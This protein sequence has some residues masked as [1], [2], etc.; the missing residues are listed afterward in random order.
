VRSHETRAARHQYPISHGPILPLGGRT[1]DRAAGVR[2]LRTSAIAWAREETPSF[3]KIALMWVFTVDPPTKRAEAISPLL[4]PS[5]TSPSTSASRR[6]SAGNRSTSAPA[7]SAGLAGGAE[8]SEPMMRAPTSG[9]K[10]AW[11]RATARTAEAS[12]AR[13]ASL[14]R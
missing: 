7:G 5:A 8:V 1:R 13:P 2:Q 3:A 14:V 9:A 4:R 10:V 12:S 6:V 11:P